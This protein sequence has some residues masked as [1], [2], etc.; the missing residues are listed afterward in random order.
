MA[1]SYNIVAEQGAT[2]YF[3]FRVEIGGVPWNLGDYSLRMQVRESTVSSTTLLN[4]T[5]ADLTT[6]GHVSIQVPATTMNNIPEGRWVYDLELE[7]S[8]GEV[9]RLLEGR[10]IV[11]PQVTQ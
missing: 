2:F 4:I 1:G 11:S 9:T 10:F 3:N 5:E 6:D 7:S 8:T